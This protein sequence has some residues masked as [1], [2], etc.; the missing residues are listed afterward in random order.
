M[1][2]MVETATTQPADLAERSQEAGG[3]KSAGGPPP[4]RFSAKQKLNAVSRLMR[5]EPL[6]LVSRELNVTA[7][8]LSSWRDQALLA[9]ETALKDRDRDDR[10]DEIVRLKG[11]VGAMT[12][13]IEL[14]VAR[15]DRAP[16]G[17]RPFGTTEV[18]AM[19]RAVS[20]SAARVYGLARVARC[21]KVSRAS[22]YRHRRATSASGCRPG[23]MGPCDDATLV[24]HIK[25]AIAESRFTGE[26]Y[27]KI[28]ARLRFSGIR[29]SPG[30]I[31]RLMRENGLLAPHRVRKRPDKAHDGTITTDAVDVMWGTD[32]TQTVT[33][34]EGAAHV[35]VAVDHCNS[36]CIG[37]HAD[38]SANRFQALEPVRQGVRRHFGVIGKTVAAGIKLRHDH[39]SNYMSDDFQTEI[40]FLGIEASASFVRE[41]EG[42]GVAERFIRTLKENLLWVRHFETIE[43]LRLALLEFAAWYNTHWLVARH[44]HRTPAQIRADQQPPLDQAA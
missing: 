17:W 33:V 27:R 24:E 9:A 18:E 44:G 3:D 34:A 20:P 30:R 39:G 5:G 36:E 23:P 43:E 11:K 42:N 21:W 10:D 12:M 16:G 41:P 22:L 13:E 32:M 31:R 25:Q 8:R 14:F 19:S 37:I 7:A 40:A 28:W 6:E 38:K 35:F 15:Q 1:D 4:R 2:G 29:S 26:G